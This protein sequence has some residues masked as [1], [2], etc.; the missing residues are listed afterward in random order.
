MTVEVVPVGK[1]TMNLLSMSAVCAMSLVLL[2]TASAD[3]GKGE[4]PHRISGVDDALN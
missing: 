4:I 1:T 2:A 3:G